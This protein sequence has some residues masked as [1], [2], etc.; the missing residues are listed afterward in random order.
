MVLRIGREFGVAAVRVPD[1]PLWFS[2]RGGSGLSGGA[3]ALLLKPWLMLM[4]RRLEA[5]GVTHN[6]RIFGVAS[7]GSMDER[8]LLEILAR[9]PPGVTE[10][11]LHPATE[12]GAAIAESMRGYRHA[13]E[14]AAL[15]S[16]RVRAAL[17]AANVSRGGYRDLPHQRP[18]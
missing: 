13:D 7:S 15:V 4:K 16:P 17:A 5:A 12:S 14:L 3:A 2:M 10:I 18:V 8:T 11:Y 1:E 6:D 9:L